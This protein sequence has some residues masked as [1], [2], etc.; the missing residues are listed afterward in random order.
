MAVFHT[1]DMSGYVEAVMIED[2]ESLMKKDPT[3]QYFKI[4][5]ANNDDNVL[6]Q[7]YEFQVQSYEPHRTTK[8][9]CYL[10]RQLGSYWIYAWSGHASKL[11][12]YD[13]DYDFSEQ[14]SALWLLIFYNMPD[15]VNYEKANNRSDCA[16]CLKHRYETHSKFPP[17]QLAPAHC[18]YLRIKISNMDVNDIQ[19]MCLYHLLD[20][21]MAKQC[22]QHLL[23]CP[24]VKQYI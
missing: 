21:H 17:I 13:G 1:S 23:D 5:E 7:K 19:S 12:G 9:Q 14:E 24:L 8:R 15:T 20:C 6:L 2:M 18:A 3:I 11:C 4:L 22:L 16:E 10:F